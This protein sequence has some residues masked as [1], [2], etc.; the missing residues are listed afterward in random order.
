MEGSA[1]EKGRAGG[2]VFRGLSG[3]TLPTESIYMHSPR[4]GQAHR[5]ARWPLEEAGAWLSVCESAQFMSFYLQAGGLG[6][7][8]RVVAVRRNSEPGRQQPLLPRDRWVCSLCP[9]PQLE[10]QTD[11]FANPREG[12]SLSTPSHCLAQPFRRGTPSGPLGRQSLALDITTGVGSTLQLPSLPH[13]P[14]QPRPPEGFSTHTSSISFGTGQASG[15]CQGP[16]DALP[17]STGGLGVYLGRPCTH[18]APR[19]APAALN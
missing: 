14:W 5:A 7:K 18:I 1:R 10:A 2:T 16:P 15:K 3:A 11:D 17:R 6:S 19:R 12:L 4:W 8:S 13:A 9:G